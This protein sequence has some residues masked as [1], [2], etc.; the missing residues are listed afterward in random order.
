M[1]AEASTSSAVLVERAADHIALVT[2]N[3]PEARNAVNAAVAQGLEKAVRETEADPDIWVVILT[4]AGEQ[5]FCAGADLKAVSSGQRSGISTEAGGF[6]GFVHMPRSKVWIAA[7]NGFALAG[8][9]EISLACD[10]IVAS[11]RAAFGL[12]EVSRG[13]VAAAGGIYRLPRALPKAI[14]LELIATAGRLD[15]QRAAA[16]GLVNRVVPHEKLKEEAIALAA[17]ICTNA[18]VAVRESLKVARRAFDLS[19]AELRRVSDEA[20]ER[21][22]RTEDFREG[23]LAFVEKRAPVWKGR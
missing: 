11:E 18:P 15:V 16:Y 14:A 6:G 17:A 12:P 21:N 20:S 9:L 8:G 23:P 10:M 3:R 7:V 5:A 1:T 19:D 13:L 4:G 2:I 22:A